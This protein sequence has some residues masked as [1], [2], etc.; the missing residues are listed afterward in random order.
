MEFVG[1]GEE[2]R[3]RRRQA[4]KK[5]IYARLSKPV[6]FGDGQKVIFFAFPFSCIRRLSEILYCGS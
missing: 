5:E 3:R 1:S 4:G 6:P 2:G